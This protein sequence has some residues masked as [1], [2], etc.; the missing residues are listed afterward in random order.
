MNPPPTEEG[1]RNF[2]A[3]PRNINDEKD[4]GAWEP[5]LHRPIGYVAENRRLRAK[6]ERLEEEMKASWIAQQA[7]N[8]RLCKLEEVSESH[9]RKIAKELTP[10]VPY[11]DSFQV[12]DSQK[13]GWR[14]I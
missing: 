10:P 11:F 4:L 13:Q 12:W 7:L 8:K 6:V 1:R 5:T 9:T 2:M 3:N 14:T